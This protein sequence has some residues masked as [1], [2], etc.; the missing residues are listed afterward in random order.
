MSSSNTMSKGTAIVGFVLSAVTGAGVMY[1][2]VRGEKPAS[3]ITATAEGANKAAGGGTGSGTGA[4][5]SAQVPIKADDPATGDKSALS[6][7]VIYSDYQCPFCSRV[8][9]TIKQ[10][11]DKY[12]KQVRFVWKDLALD[13]HKNALPAATA[14]RVA[15]MA[16]GNDAFW[17][18]H[19]TMFS[20]QKDLGD[21]NFV[22][23]LAEV[24]VSKADYDRLKPA[25]EA[26]V[27]ASMDEAKALGISGTPNFMIDG[28]ALTGAQ[29]VDKFTAVIDAHI[30]KAQELKAKGTTDQAL[31][32]EMVKAFYKKAAPADDG[33]D[34]PPAEDMTVWK[35]DI[36]D[37]PVKGKADALVTIVTY[38]D[39]QCPFCKRVDPTIEKVKADYGDAVRI[40]WKNAPLPFHNRAIPCANLAMEAYKEKGN[41]GFWTA[42]EKIFESNPKLED[43]D[44]EAI[45]KTM[46]LDGAKV[47]DA[48]TTNKYKDAIQKDQDQAEDLQVH[49]TPHSFVNGRV[50]NGAVPYEDFKKVVDQE[51]AKAKA[52]VA[53]GT[54]ASKVYEE[55]VKAGKGGAMSPLSIPATAPWK[56]GKDAKVVV[57]IFSDFQCPFC[58]RAEVAMPGQ[59]GK[60]DPNGAGMK[61]AFDLYGDK[62]KVVWRNFPL[63]FHNRAEPAA[64]LAI[65]AFHQKGN[66]GFWAA[67][68]A[69]FDSQ[70]KI[71]DAD[72]EAIAKKIG[73]DWTKCKAAIDTHK[74]KAEIDQD[75][76]DGGSVGVTGTPAFIIGLAGPGGSLVAGKS[77]VGA[78]PLDAFKKAIDAALAHAH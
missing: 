18:M 8:E 69:L 72:L 34:K 19:D 75:Q 47:H 60:V 76:K 5:Q 26:R 52:K 56:G 39:F 62:I 73:L 23:W 6:T 37:A 45:G 36:G 48:I 44:L 3:E 77:V 41:E 20:N 68:D 33:G 74:Y 49:G 27:K 46:G 59:D 17:K 16:K 25:A 51:L 1:A 2:V 9:P 14:A 61:A 10:I 70:P 12:G 54:P 35:V 28:E 53:S 7:V 57:M 78:Q 64:E 67:H 24:G 43:A 38:S 65:E 40:V 66:E 22:K 21:D 42:H 30:K 29:P 11:K 63:G 58:K 4:D 71:E 32:P 13:F 50:V 55:T 31:Y 15:Y